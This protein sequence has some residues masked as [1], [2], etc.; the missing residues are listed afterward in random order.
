MP[1]CATT[2]A[3]GRMDCSLGLPDRPVSQA[4]KYRST[5][6]VQT[7][8]AWVSAVVHEMEMVGRTE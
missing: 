3:V 5:D 6:G 7:K 8:G 1:I 4:S 2:I